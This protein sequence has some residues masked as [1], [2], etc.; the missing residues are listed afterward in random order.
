M[1]KVSIVSQTYNM[2]TSERILIKSNELFKKFGIRAVTLDE[3]SNVLGISK[4]TIYQF[5]ED[6]DTLVD[7][8]MM[9]EFK[10]DYEECK[11]CS[12]NAK[13]AIEEIFMLM[14]NMDRDFRN[15]NPIILFDLK[16]FHFKTHQKFMQHIH[17]NMMQM[18]VAN[19]KRGITEG[20][21]RENL[22]VETIARYRMSSMWLLFEP[23]IFPSEQFELQKIFRE[24]SELFLH[25]LV[26][27]KGFKLIEKYHQQNVDK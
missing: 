13:N 14:E 12:I 8:V 11:N 22:E 4:K 9:Q 3:I 19:L 7:A 25:G 20:F 23:E 27:A 1:L 26:N 2:E 10:K 15:M 21:Y 24:I 17:Q 6:K 16:K 5:F 18:I